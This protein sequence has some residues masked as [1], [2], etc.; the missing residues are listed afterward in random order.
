MTRKVDGHSDLCMQSVA[1]P[2]H[3]HRGR[4]S[5]VRLKM[6]SDANTEMKIQVSCSRHY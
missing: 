5:L 6:Q 3:H 2:T 4:S 1:R